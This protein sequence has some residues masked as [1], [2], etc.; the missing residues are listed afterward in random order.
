MYENVT[1]LNHHLLRPATELDL[2]L[3]QAGFKAV[4]RQNM[5][6]VIK[7]ALEGSSERVTRLRGFC[8]STVFLDV[9]VK[10]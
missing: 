6:T 7:N 8:T 10:V 5:Q 9:E 1:S 4:S 3:T 2:A